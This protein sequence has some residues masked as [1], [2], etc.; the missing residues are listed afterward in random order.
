M[1]GYVKTTKR[2]GLA[3]VEFFH[4][5]GNSMPS[6]QLADLA[7]AVENAG[8]DKEV[9][10]IL[11]KSAGE[12]AFCAGAN[13][14]ELLSISNVDEGRRFFMG[15][16]NVI[17]AMRKAPQLV[18]CRVQGKCVGGGVGLAAAADY[19]VATTASEVKL[20]ELAVGLGPFVVG[21]AV[22]RKTGLSAFSQMTI[23]AT[24]FH[25][26]QWA[27]EKGLFTDTYDT[28]EAL[29]AAIDTLVSTLL[30]SNPEAMFALKKVFWKDTGHWDDLLMERAETS[31]RLVLSEYSR[32]FLRSR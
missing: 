29:D 21:P 6:Q 30:A 25:S 22:E 9:K 12:K 14:D 1:E 16:A 20:S 24:A 8:K 13:F 32:T 31:G 19:T 17:N 2:D 27:K 3:T 28:I 15:F 4:P 23:N 10:L 26:A 18:I 11:L 7:D 5:K